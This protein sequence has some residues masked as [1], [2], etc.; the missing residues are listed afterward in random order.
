MMPGVLGGLLSF[1]AVAHGQTLDVGD[2]FPDWSMVDQTG[3]SVTSV[4]YTGRRYVLWF[5]AE[6]MTPTC[7]AQGRGFRDHYRQFEAAGITV[8]AVSFDVPQTNGVFASAEGFP[9]PLLTDSERGF[10]LRVGAIESEDEA[11]PQPLSYLVGE[12]GRVVKLYTRVH[13][14]EILLDVGVT[15]P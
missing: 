8:L 2:E 1:L 3:S 13:A 9:F 12:D 6:A 5:C 10:S 15:A 4:S 14:Q 11:R 7:T